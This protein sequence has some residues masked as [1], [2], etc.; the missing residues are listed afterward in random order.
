MDPSKNI[1]KGVIFLTKDCNIVCDDNKHFELITPKKK[2]VFKTDDNE[3]LVWL[4]IINEIK[5]FQ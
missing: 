5:N 3:S 1:V 2:F 4:K